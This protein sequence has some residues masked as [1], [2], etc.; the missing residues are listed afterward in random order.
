MQ[1]A[2]D[3]FGAG[4]P[5]L[6]A[7]AGEAKSYAERLFDFSSVGALDMATATQAI[8]DPIHNEG[9]NLGEPGRDRAR[10]GGL[11]LL[12]RMGQTHLTAGER[13]RDQPERCAGSD[14]NGTNRPRQQFF[15]CA[16]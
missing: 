3:S 8:A 16:V 6:A 14:R 15:P 5:Q 12:P 7:L 9:L 13:S 1:A 11:P 4:L 10:D 2:D